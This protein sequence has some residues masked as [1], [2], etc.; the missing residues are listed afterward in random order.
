MKVYC[1][2][3]TDEELEALTA[4]CQEKGWAVKAMHGFG[5]PRNGHPVDLVY[6]A[7]RVAPSIRAA[8]RKLNMPPAT[9]YSILKKGGYL[10][11]SL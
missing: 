7:F 4:F 8:A 3:G 2:G 5:R 1:T 11:D 6:D 10:G 9:V